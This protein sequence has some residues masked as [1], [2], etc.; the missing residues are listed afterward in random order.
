MDYLEIKELMKDMETSSL[1]SIE[2]ELPEGTKVKMRKSPIVYAGMMAEPIEKTSVT[3][4]KVSTNVNNMQNNT[5]EN[6]EKADGFST[7]F[8]LLDMNEITNYCKKFDIAV[9]ILTN[10]NKIVKFCNWEK[11]EKL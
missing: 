10:N 2:I 8:Y 3:T 9:L 1:D 5:T 7:L 11:Y 4:E 6:T